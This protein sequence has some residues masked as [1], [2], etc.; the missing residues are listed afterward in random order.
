[1][2]HLHCFYTKLVVNLFVHSSQHTE[3]EGLYE[4]DVVEYQNYYELKYIWDLYKKWKKVKDFASKTNA[5][6]NTASSKYRINYLNGGGHHKYVYPY[7]VAS[8]HSDSRENAPRLY[9][10]HLDSNSA[11]NR[12]WPDFPRRNCHWWFTGGELCSVDYEGINRLFYDKILWG[13]PMV[14]FTG[15][16]V[17]DFPGGDLI[18]SIIA[19][20][21]VCGMLSH[22]GELGPQIHRAN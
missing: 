9:T 22:W 13:G 7:F 16:V 14:Q 2:F 4:G 19:R 17:M 15:V 20:N 12:K 8:G 21:A 11:S 6:R 3:S 18:T 1:M 5:Q 10:G